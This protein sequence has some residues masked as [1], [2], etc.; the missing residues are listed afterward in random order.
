MKAC[1]MYNVGLKRPVSI[2]LFLSSTL[3]TVYCWR[4]LHQMRQLKRP[5]LELTV[6]AKNED[7]Y[8][9]AQMFYFYFSKEGLSQSRS[10]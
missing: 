8:P 6:N 3:A 9:L 7:S 10:L 1:D 4:L 2:P 5:L